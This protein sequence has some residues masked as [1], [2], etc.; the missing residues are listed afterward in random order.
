[1]YNEEKKLMTDIQRKK[2]LDSNLGLFADVAFKANFEYACHKFTLNYLTLKDMHLDGDIPDDPYIA[3]CQTVIDKLV[4]DYIADYQTEAHDG[5][6]QAA[7]ADIRLISEVRDTITSKMKVL[8]SYTDAFEMYEYILNRKEYSYQENMTDDLQAELDGIDVSEFAD[9]I[10]RFVFADSDKVAINSKLQ[11][12]I[13]QLPIRMTKNRFYD[14]LGDTLDIYNGVEK[15]SLDQFIDMVEST[16]LI[17]LP[18]GFETEYP[19]LYTALG[20]LKN[21]DYTDLDAENYRKLADVLDRSAQFL[22]SVVTEYMLIVEL[23]NDLYVMLLAIS[24]RDD[25]SDKCHKAMDVIANA[26]KADDGDLEAVYTMLNDIV[27]EQE[28]AGEHKV[29]LESAVYDITTGYMEEIA[30]NGLEATFRALETM[31]KLL[32]GSMFVDISNVAIAGVLKVDSDYIAACKEKL[33]NEFAELFTGNSMTVNRAI[34]A[35]ILS[36][37]PVFFNTTD[38]I[39]EYIQGAL[40]RCREQSELLADYIVIKQ[41]MEE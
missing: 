11:S 36:N 33:A 21:A 41:M 17:K 28:N 23:V 35:K 2:D 19:D 30:E 38:E 1:M 9:E 39:K 10:F 18:E 27:G 7:D 13:G 15:E 26:M 14:I 34:M 22:N 4:S 40:S 25:T 16:A 37:I 12:L 20:I 6:Y 8:T 5:K 29:M 31:D 24:A 32:S 3:H